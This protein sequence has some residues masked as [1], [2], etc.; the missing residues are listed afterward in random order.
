MKRAL[1]LTLAALFV[2][3][4]IPA[5]F[6]LGQGEHPEGGPPTE[7]DQTAPEETA[8]IAQ[9]VPSGDSLDGTLLL[10]VLLSDGTVEQ[11]PLDDYLAGVILA[12]M[13][14]S[15][16]EE[17]LKAQAVV[18]RTY[19]LRQTARKK[20]ADADICTDPSCCQ[21]WISYEDYCAKTGDDGPDCAQAAAQAVKATDGLVL[22]YDGAL[23]DA[24][25]FSCSG[26]R[27]ET[28]V[29]VW[30][31]DVPYLQ[32]V[33][34][35]GEEA[36]HNA[37]TVSF[38]AEEFSARILSQNPGADLSG[39]PSSWFGDTSVTEGGGV[40]A[41][42]IGGVFF[43]G[44]EL[45]SLLGLRSTVFTVSVLGDEIFFQTR[46]YGHRVGM[47]QYGAQAMAQAGS[48]C[49]EILLHYY[50][51]VELQNYFSAA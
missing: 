35:P 39:L 28:A 27:T 38:S 41:L 45:R 42:E 31:S 8:G 9:T 15:F 47:S 21:G 12:E 43:S 6:L 19:T 13:P 30:G 51:G 18:S 24:T 3:L 20:H 29:E 10:Q 2:G 17:A 26:G 36:P 7:P 49:E 25:F 46:G 44:K 34:S 1:V 32:S 4:C 23:I 16:E 48:S 14:A 22:V 40:E 5:L 50:T 33:E 37:D 11:K